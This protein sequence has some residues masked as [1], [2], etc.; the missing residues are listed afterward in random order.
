VHDGS[1]GHVALADADGR[2]AR[3]LF[4]EVGYIYMGALAPTDR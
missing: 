4:P 3:L 2:N 1:T